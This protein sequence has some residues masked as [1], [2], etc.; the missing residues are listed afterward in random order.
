MKAIDI[1]LRIS[2]IV[3]IVGSF[4]LPDVVEWKL[5][6]ANFFAVGLWGVLFPAGPLGWAKA[7]YAELNPDDVTIWW[8]S[9]LIGS[10]F[11][12][13]SLIVAVLIFG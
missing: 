10:V 7:A 12:A 5:I 8:L 4:V 1:C 6:C 11:M 3:A 2:T 13:L 9:R